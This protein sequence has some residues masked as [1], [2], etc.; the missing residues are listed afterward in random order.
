M[1]AA[2]QFGDDAWTSLRTLW[3]EERWLPAGIPVAAVAYALWLGISGAGLSFLLGGGEGSGLAAWLGTT[4]GSVVGAV[5]WILGPAAL[6]TVLAVDHVKNVNGNV[7]HGYRLG[8]PLVLLWPPLAVLGVGY[9]LLVQT[10]QASLPA[11]GVLVAGGI[12]LAVRTLA[13]AYR[14]FSLGYPIFG[15]A[16]TF[17]TVTALAS[18]SLVAGGLAAGREQAVAALLDGLAA[19]TGQAAIASAHTDVATVEGVAMPLV[20]AVAV[21]TPVVAAGA[22][23]AL[24]VAWSVL[25]R[26]WRPTVK[27]PELRTGQRYPAF[28]R[29]TTRPLPTLLQDLAGVPTAY[30]PG[31]LVSRIRSRAPSGSGAT[32]ADGTAGNG[33]A[34]APDGTAATPA[35]GGGPRSVYAGG[36]GV[37]NRTGSSTSGS[38]ATSGSTSGQSGA[39]TSA[40]PSSG[41]T[42]SDR[43]GGGDDAGDDAGGDGATENVS[44]TRVFTPPEDADFAATVRCPACGETVDATADDCPV[45]G[46]AI[47]GA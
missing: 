20:A 30:R 8:H 45:C 33:Q 25:V 14:V 4:T 9:G 24:Q 43:D 46:E 26:L 23:V 22:Y 47:D 36:D 37:S 21:G 16:V 3:R 27:R 15:Q 41:Q 11:L 31:S 18:A 19:T 10:G 6:A 2:R 12:W 7:R 17:A 42:G 1:D 28:A 38:G 39:N 29:P 5:L 44:H 40:S 32:S 35:D 34:D 13:Y